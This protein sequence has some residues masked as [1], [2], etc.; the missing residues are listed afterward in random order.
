MKRLAPLFA[1]LKEAVKNLLSL[2]K[3]LLLI[4]TALFLLALAIPAGVIHYFCTI[5]SR[6]QKAREIMTKTGNFSL[7]GL[8]GF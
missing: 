6:K 7:S 1:W 2:I 3:G 8:P 4:P 5:G